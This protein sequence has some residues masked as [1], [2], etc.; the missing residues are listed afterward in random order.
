MAADSSGYATVN[1][2]I[3]AGYALTEPAGAVTAVS[4][5]W[6]VPTVSPVGTSGAD[7]KSCIWVGIDGADT[8]TVEQVGTE[9]DV[10]NGKANYYCWWEMCSTKGNQPQQFISNFSVSPG[11]RITASVQYLQTAD[12]FGLSIDDLTTGQSFSTMQAS[13]ATQSPLA[14]RT[15]AEWIVEDPT[16][17]T[18]QIPYTLADFGTA[19]FENA[20]ASI[21]GVSAT[22]NGF[23]QTPVQ[24]RISGSTGNTSV[25]DLFASND[26]A[27]SG[28]G[29]SVQFVAPIIGSDPDQSPLIKSVTGGDGTVYL[30]HSDGDL[31]VERSTQWG[32]GY[33]VIDGN[34]VTSLLLAGDGSVYAIE[35]GSGNRLLRFANGVASIVDSNNVTQIAAAGDGAV[36]AIEAA[37]GNCLVKWW[38]GQRYVVDNNNV[39]QIAAAGD[40]AVYA[41]EAANG[42][43]L[44]KWWQ[45]QRYVVDSNNVTQIAAAGDGAVYAIEAGNGH[46][47]V[48]WWEGQRYVVDSN[49]VTQIAAAGD[50]AVYAIEAGNGDTL[51]KWWEGQRYIVDSPSD[52]SVILWDGFQNTAT[53][54][55][56]PTPA[57]SD[58]SS[59]TSPSNVFVASSTDSPPV[60]ITT[61]PT[62]AVI[63]IFNRGQTTVARLVTVKLFASA[64]G[65]LDDATQ[66]ATGRRRLR[67]EAGRLSRL[68]LRFSS[69]KVLLNG[70]H[71]L[72]AVINSPEA[73]NG[74]AKMASANSG[75][76]V[77]VK[78]AGA[79]S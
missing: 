74:N 43:C 56:A 36:Y 69:R 35:A 34:D 22:I 45:G 3:W 71:Y 63:E 5:A 50:G 46:N 70:T 58:S 17:S 53:A 25:E 27:V 24:Y 9:Q 52:G 21:D 13:A 19:T 15:T 39:T 7:A 67:L 42:N 65:L 48:K 47:L 41:I 10:S 14:T 4:G 33:R 1:N 37:K 73:A 76:A 26:G 2:P 38:E 8:P 40:G 49:N 6:T 11:D 54:V 77:T 64:D 60:A 78:V 51:V 61:K 79:G 57:S 62:S 75:L 16:N 68:T 20:R 29:F 66:I 72:V 12:Q 59:P 32:E 18:T 44:V 30:L 55:V 31:I 23:G 28:S